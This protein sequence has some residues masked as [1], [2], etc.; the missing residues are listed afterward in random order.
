MSSPIFGKALISIISVVLTLLLLEIALNLITPPSLPRAKDLLERIGYVLEPVP[1]AKLRV[2]LDA[3]LANRDS[4]NFQSEPHTGWT[5]RASA[6]LRFGAKFT[7]NA[8]GFRSTREF[9]LNPSANTIRIAAFGD[10]FTA[11]PDVADDKVWAQ[12]LED[13]LAARG[14]RAEVLNFGVGGYGM[15]QAYLRWR[16]LGLGFSPDIVVFGFHPENLKRNVNVFRPLYFPATALPF[17]KPRFILVDGA[18]DLVNFPAV[19]PEELMQVYERFGSPALAQHEFYYQ[20]GDFFTGILAKSKL[21]ILLRQALAS[22]ANTNADDLSRSSER[23]S[24]GL[25]ILDTFA[26]TVAAMN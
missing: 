15:G 25:A 12:V 20:G 26:H 16:H 8:H 13:G 2:G 14:I 5:Y 10:S 9:E 6:R 3:Y 1:L 4:A 7:T 21:A 22:R 19:P 18:L 23:G 11:G 24:L 17:S